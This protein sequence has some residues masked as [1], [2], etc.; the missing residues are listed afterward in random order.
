MNI[1][2]VRTSRSLSQTFIPLH[3]LRYYTCI[4]TADTT[5]KIR[6][7][8]LPFL[9]VKRKRIPNPNIRIQ[10]ESYPPLEL[11]C[12]NQPYLLHIPTVPTPFRTP[13]LRVPL[14]HTYI[15]TKRLQTSRMPE[16]SVTQNIKMHCTALLGVLL[17]LQHGPFHPGHRAW[18]GTFP[19]RTTPYGPVRN[20]AGTQ[21][22]AVLVQLRP[23]DLGRRTFG[24]KQAVALFRF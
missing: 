11:I 8:T 18:T 14:L 24:P 23:M 19:T 7:H 15:H 9:F 13:F 21:D 22:R 3:L 20:D 6:Y 12:G 2:P 17:T 5:T 10:C 1:F 16:T 4:H